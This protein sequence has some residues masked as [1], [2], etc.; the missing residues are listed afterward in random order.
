VQQIEQIIRDEIAKSGPM[1]MGRFMALA[2]GHPEHGYYNTRDPFGTAGDFTTAPEISQIFGEMI[3]LWCAQMWMSFGAPARF[4]LL[5]CGPGRGTLMADML[6]AMEKVADAVA[7]CRP[8]LLEMSPV[9]R[10]AQQKALAG[11]DAVWIEDVLELEAIGPVIVIGNEFLDALPVRQFVKVGD[12]WAER[13]LDV[14]EGNNIYIMQPLEGG[15]D[16]NAEVVGDHVSVSRL[17]DIA[18]DG[19]VIE[20]SEAVAGFL[21]GVMDVCGD[22]VAGL[23]IDYGHLTS[24]LGDTMQA[25]YKHQKVNVLSHIGDAD[26]TAHVDF[27]A[28]AEV[29][30]RAGGHTYFAEQGAFLNALGA[31]VRAQALLKAAKDQAQATELMRGYERLVRDDQMGSLFKVMGFSKGYDDV[32][33]GF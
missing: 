27:E 3:G 9:L 18:M 12:D 2:L 33:P 7:A 13:C 10:A 11:R 15:E 6:R 29:L 31:G 19:D 26:I 24:G 21:A 20:V 16:V 28:A 30:K 23:F 8:V 5:E 17:R 4:T 22:Q 32:L 1:D 25:L 14:D